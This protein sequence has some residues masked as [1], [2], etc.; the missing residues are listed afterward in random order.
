[1]THGYGTTEDGR[2]EVTYDGIFGPV[3]SPTYATAAEAK[4]ACEQQAAES[5]AWNARGLADAPHMDA[6]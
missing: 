2:W 3:G 6:Y 1:M 5:R 4:A